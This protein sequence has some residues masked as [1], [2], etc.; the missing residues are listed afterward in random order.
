MMI[1]I[2]AAPRALWSIAGLELVIVVLLVLL[3]G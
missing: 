2:N 1:P 3:L